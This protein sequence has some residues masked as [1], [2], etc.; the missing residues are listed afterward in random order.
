MKSAVLPVQTV[1]KVARP[2]AMSKE[3]HTDGLFEESQRNIT[4]TNQY[5]L[6]IVIANSAHFCPLAVPSIVQLRGEKHGF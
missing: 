1:D 2:F 3:S 6:L 5:G 4:L